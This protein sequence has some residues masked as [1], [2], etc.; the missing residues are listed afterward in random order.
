MPADLKLKPGWLNRDV[1][2]ATKKTNEW[3]ASLN[4]RTQKADSAR[5]TT[6]ER[7]HSTGVD[8]DKNK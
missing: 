7:T 4:R 8:K 1:S 6:G 2:Q 3:E 5:Q